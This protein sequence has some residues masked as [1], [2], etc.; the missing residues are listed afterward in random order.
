[1][2][3]LIFWDI[4]GR[5]WRKAFIKEFEA[6]KEKYEADLCI[7]NIE[8]IT[9]GRGPASIHA[10]MID[11]VWVDLMTWWDHVFDNMPD[12]ATY[13]WKQNCKLIRPANFL[14]P[15]KYPLPWDGY[16][17][18]TTN[19]WYR[20]LVIQLLGEVFMN[21]KVENPF[22]KVTE[23]LDSISESEYDT[24]F[25]EFHKEATAEF[26]GM[27][28]YLDGRVSLV[29]GTHTHIQTNDAQVLAWGTGIITD[30]WMNGP[31]NSVIGATFESVEKRFLSGIS[32]GKI[33]QQLKGKYI[34]NAIIVDIDEQLGRCETIENISFTWQL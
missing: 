18:I 10:Q 29:Y 5:L 25:V 24:C 26:Y 32:K 17:I 7:V 28:H 2:R 13:F 1:V 3:A 12:I 14:S 15:D 4:Y 22:H 33:M 27:A 30:I 34:I 19:S 9:S 11:N 16:K 21:H 23:I 31:Y 8:N 20:I 6:L